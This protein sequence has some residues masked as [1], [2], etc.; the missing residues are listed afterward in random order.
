MIRILL[1]GA[2]G[3]MGSRIESLCADPL[4]GCSI[5]WRRTGPADADGGADCDVLVDFSSDSGARDA[6]AIARGRSVPLVSGTTGLTDATRGLL[7]EASEEIAVLHASNTSLGVAV[8]RRLV[9]QMARALRGAAGRGFSLEI[10]ETHH[11]HKR[12][13]PSG[14]ALALADAIDCGLA[15][16]EDTGAVR[17]DRS[18]ITSVRQGEVIGDHEVR[19]RGPG[20]ILSIHHHAVSRDLFAIGALRLAT[21]MAK[22]PPGLHTVDDWL[23]EQMAPSAGGARR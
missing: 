7:R 8:A 1:N 10:V 5:A 3:R 20:E 12:D 19:A 21:W 2:G 18:R 22:R 9:E 15:G 16:G 23:D 14:T 13:A 6:V 17:F 4:H 11:V